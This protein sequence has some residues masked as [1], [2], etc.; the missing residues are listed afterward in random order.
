[1]SYLCRWIDKM[2]GQKVSEAA[3]SKSS[4]AHL[5]TEVV[6]ARVPTNVHSP[7][8]KSRPANQK[9]ER[10]RFNDNKNSKNE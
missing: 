3:K 9:S 2:Y 8:T 10:N 6:L 7:L 4:L 5:N 1:M